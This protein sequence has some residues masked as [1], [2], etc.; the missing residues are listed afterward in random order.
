ML[1]SLKK[2]LQSDQTTLISNGEYKLL[3]YKNRI[4]VI[5]FLYCRKSSLQT[6]F[7]T[8]DY[9]HRSIFIN[10]YPPWFTLKYIIKNN[11]R[12]I[13]LNNNGLCAVVNI[14]AKPDSIYCRLFVCIRSIVFYFVIQ[15]NSCLLFEY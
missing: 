8:S 9:C 7:L 3:Q 13:H 12:N 14:C 6:L 11:R 15:Y 10:Y 2:Y 1:S 5:R 4:D